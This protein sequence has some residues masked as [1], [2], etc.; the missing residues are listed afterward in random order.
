MLGALG[1]G[2]DY[3]PFI[4]HL[5]ISSLNVGFGGEDPGGEYH[6][7]YD[8]YDNYRRFKDPTFEY[9]VALAKTAGRTAL[10]L[11]NAEALPFDFKA[12]YKTV[13]GYASELISIADQLRE[14]TVL[15]NQLIKEK[16][17]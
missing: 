16:Y 3:S 4:Q 1:S 17:Y 10:R 13:N 6:S 9:G 8:S 2:S 14:N 15:E 12:F 7:I 11:A 5:G